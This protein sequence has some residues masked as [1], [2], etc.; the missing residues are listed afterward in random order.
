MSQARSSWP[1]VDSIC[2]KS[3]RASAGYAPDVCHRAIDTGDRQPGPADH[4]WTRPPDL[5]WPDVPMVLAELHRSLPAGATVR[6]DLA[7]PF[8]GRPVSRE[9]RPRPDF[10]QL[11]TGAGFGPSR[12]TSEDPPGGPSDTTRLVVRQHTLADTVHGDL[13]LLICGINPSLYSADAGVAYARP[14]NRFWPAALATGIVTDDRD[15]WAA[16]RRG[17]GMTDLVKRPSRTASE[18]EAEEYAVGFTRV[19]ELVAWLT[20]GAVCF[21]GL[22]G[23]RT[24]VDRKAVPGHQPARIGGRPVYVMPSTSGLNAHAT[25]GDLS[26]HLEA[27][28]DLGRTAR[29][30]TTSPVS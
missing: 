26:A 15:A 12:P 24:V 6:I 21:V 25:L 22:S 10:E 2:A 3:R 13:D 8:D 14:G 17:I 20:P 28:A 30:R 27:A 23:W 7:G 29:E 1:T 18:V 5:S 4:I 9:A 19:E 16:A 11:L